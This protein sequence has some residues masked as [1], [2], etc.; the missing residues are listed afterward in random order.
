[1]PLSGRTLKPMRGCP[2]KAA[3]ASVE[4]SE[5]ETLV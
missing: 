1:M 4:R 3:E 5:R 2:A